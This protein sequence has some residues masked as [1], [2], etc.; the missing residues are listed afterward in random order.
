MTTPRADA[1]LR[2]L[3]RS[4]GNTPML[5]I[6][7]RFRGRLFTIY[8]KSEQHN[9]TGSIKDRMALHVL[10]RAH[11]AGLLPPGSTIAEA[12]S[13]NSGISFAA[14]GRALGHEVTIF[15]P[16]WMSRERVE[17]IRSFGATV[18]PV[19]QEQGGFLG[20]IA[21]ADALAERDPT[22]FLPHQFSNNSNVEAHEL[23]TGPEIWHQLA[24]RQLVPDGFVAGV[25]TGG[26]AMGVGRFLRSQNRAVRVHPVE[27]SE[28]PTLTTGCKVGKHRIQGVSDEFIPTIVELDYLDRPIAVSDGD[29][30]LMAR[31]LA[32]QLGLGVGISSGANFLA[33]LLLQAELG[34]DAVITTVFPDDNKKYLSTAL[35]QD[36]PRRADYLTPEV[37]LR[38]YDVIRRVCRT[39]CD[40]DECEHWG[41]LSLQLACE[42]TC[43]G[44]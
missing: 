41:E 17:L 19:S 4:I 33:A 31:A 26:T 28:S 8:A 42:P 22:V 25:G 39:C 36:E 6:E 32:A 29:A 10:R 38:S 5:A 30:I 23:A 9:L 24:T 11:N 37:E 1:V 12:T 18:V 34:A 13:G 40:L 15:M 14:I 21:L 16:D 27:P 43:V 44:C 3:S 2:G 7:C 20:A 35:L